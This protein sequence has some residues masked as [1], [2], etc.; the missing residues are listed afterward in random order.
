MN[1]DD[2]IIKKTKLERDIAQATNSILK[3]FNDDTK[4]SVNYVAINLIEISKIGDTRKMFTVSG[5]DVNLS[6]WDES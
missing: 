4:I 5:C 2:L 3:K 1:I 6:I